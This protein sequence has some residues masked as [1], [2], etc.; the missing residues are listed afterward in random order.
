MSST[1]LESARVLAA[2]AETQNGIALGEPLSRRRHRPGTR[3][4]IRP[5]VVRLIPGITR[6]PII[7]TGSPA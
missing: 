1:N 5:N 6:L 2:T 7:P 3:L 4:V